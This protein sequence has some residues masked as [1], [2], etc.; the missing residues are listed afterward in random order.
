MR[1]S[2]EWLSDYIS[3]LP[4]VNETSQILTDIGLEVESVEGVSEFSTNGLVVGE[5]IQCEQHPNADR[6]KVTKVNIGADVLL[7]IVCGAPNVA[8]GQKVIV[9]TI[10][11]EL[12]PISGDAFKIKESKIRGELSQGMLCAEDEIGIGESHSGI[13]VLPEQAI[14]GNPIDDYISKPKSSAVFEI[15]LTPNRPDAASHFGVARD[16]FAALYENDQAQLIKPKLA[17]IEVG[18]NPVKIEVKNPEH[19]LRYSALTFSGIEVKESPDWLKSR[20]A[21]VGLKSINNV[22]DITNYVMLETGQPLHAF[23]REKLTNDTIQVRAAFENESIVTLDGTERTLNQ[24]DLV[25]A[26]SQ[27]A[28]CIAGVYGGLNSG[29]SNQ[30]NSIVLESACFNPTSVRKTSKRL[31][32]KTDSSFRFERGSDINATV[33]ALN[34]AALLLQ[35]LASAKIEGK[36]FDVIHGNIAPHDIQLSKE[37]LSRIIGENIEAKKVAKILKR[38]QIEITNETDLAWYL[39][40]PTFK[41]DVT[42]PADVAEE[43]LRIYGFNNIH[44]PTIMRSNP[45]ANDQD[46]NIRIKTRIQ[47][48]LEGLGFA[49]VMNNSLTSASYYTEDEQNKMVRMANPLSSELEVMRGSMLFGL[50]ENVAYNQNRQADDLKLVEWGKTYLQTNGKYF[51]TNHLSLV[52]TGKS[53]SESAL[54]TPETNSFQ[55]LKGIAEH[56]LKRLGFDFSIKINPSESNLIEWVVARK[57]IGQLQWVNVAILKKFSINQPVAFLDFNWDEIFKMHEKQQ[58]QFSAIPKFPHVRRDLA[59]LIDNDTPFE[60][61]RNIAL[62]TERKILKEVNLFDVYKGDKLPANKKSY[63]LS[64]VFLDEEKTLTDQ[65]IEQ[66]MQKLISNYAK[67]VGAT[68]R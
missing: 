31:G 5:V 43:V 15:G 38:L 32:L 63:A 4:A 64:F 61:L 9:A 23:D 48:I 46:E 30:T 66:I 34:R 40:V 2:Y 67:E 49:E 42:R 51:E 45:V 28:L 21:E 3:P 41:V 68:L 33:D 39:K 1:I 8:V 20:L 10:G 53:W 6:L 22:V 36:V 16:L 37:Y 62:Q 18:T 60:K 54:K 11:T 17:A 55:L 13:L 65:Q 47:S 27:Q 35:E 29:V 12:H 44:F 59:L 24:S 7:S 25:I 19:C 14:V 57:S 56:I 26:D 50:L 52:I 58:I